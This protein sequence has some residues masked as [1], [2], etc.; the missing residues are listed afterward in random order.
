MIYHGRDSRFAF[1]CASGAFGAEIGNAAGRF[2]PSVCPAW[3]TDRRCEVV[4][5]M[6]YALGELP[7][8]RR[9]NRLGMVSSGDTVLRRVKA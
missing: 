9:L 8:S 4:R 7:G 3:D 1:I 5:L 2:S 6:G